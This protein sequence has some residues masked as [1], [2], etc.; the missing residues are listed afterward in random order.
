[1]EPVIVRGL[2]IG[3]GRPK[4]IVPVLGET[5]EQ[6]LAEAEQ[7]KS[8]P[9]DLA[10]WRLDWY[11]GVEN[12]DEL[13][14][15]AKSL[16]ETLGELPILATFRTA[17]E[18]G[19]RHISEEGY[20]H[21]IR[22]LAES[23][24]VD[25]IDI[26]VFTGDEL[27]GELIAFC[28]EKGV[29]VVLSNHDFDKTPPEAELVK[30]LQKMEELGADLSK[31]AVMPRSPEDVL[32]LL[33]ATRARSR[34]SARPVVTMSMGALGAVSRLSGQVFGS[35]LTFGSAARASAPGQVEAGKLA[36]TLELLSLS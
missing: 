25:L 15:A 16:R 2:S 9:A 17:K 20:A 35:A 36:Q 6:L 11:D 13:L 7:V 30:R 21:I 18:G 19:Q 26:E 14:E 24:L 1:M 27:V 33:S 8:V 3:T 5:L 4:I 29:K 12:T 34:V 22:T 32:T 31:I 28:H 23:G 10:E